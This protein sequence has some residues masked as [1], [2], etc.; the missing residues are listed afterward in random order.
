MAVGTQTH[1][2]NVALA[3]SSVERT[4]RYYSCWDRIRK[5]KVKEGQ[6][7]GTIA[8]LMSFSPLTTASILWD[9]DNEISYIKVERGRAQGLLL[10]WSYEGCEWDGITDNKALPKDKF[11]D[12]GGRCFPQRLLA[13][14]DG[15]LAK[16]QR[17]F[18]RVSQ[19]HG[20]Q[21]MLIR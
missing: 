2:A 7:G 12:H 15:F 5:R 8:G 20:T 21:H 18:S 9:R 1:L 19:L 6:I 16:P 13:N 3:H 17:P 10:S 11:F 4:A 14:P